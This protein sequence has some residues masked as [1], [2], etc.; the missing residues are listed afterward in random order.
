ML[1]LLV[2]DMQVGVMQGQKRFDANGVVQRINELAAAVRSTGGA[3]I[4]IQHEGKTG[5]PYERNTPRWAILPELD[6]SAEDFVIAKSACDAFYRT[7]LGATLRQTGIDQLLIT[8]CCT[9][10]CVDTTVRA[11]ASLD[12]AV[13]V[14]SDAHTTANRPHLKAQAIITHH[15]WVWSGLILPGR[16]IRVAPT[17]EII[18]EL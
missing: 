12:Y 6:R 16:R 8:G 14:V 4:Y 13:T 18:Q 1:G 11:A 17:N 7:D 2:I 3:V 9:D 5:G 10:F 15:N